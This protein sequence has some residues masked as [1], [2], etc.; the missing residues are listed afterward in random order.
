MGNAK[1]FRLFSIDGCH[2]APSTAVDME[3]AFKCL[4]DGG[5][6]MMDDYF[7]FCWPGVSEGVSVFM[8]KNVNCLKPFL[9]AWNKVFFTQPKYAEIYKA[10][11]EKL[12]IP[13]DVRRKKF[14]DVETL[15]YDPQS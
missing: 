10:V 15:I 4:V 2:E 6:V 7:H 11:L 13:N 1:G 14:F 3:N 9:I 12:F 8:T 5:I